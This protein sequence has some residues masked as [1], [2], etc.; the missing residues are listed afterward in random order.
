MESICDYTQCT[1][2]MACLNI[3]PHKAIHIT[4]DKEGF[5]RPHIEKEKC[6]DCGLCRQK[7]PANTPVSTH[8][9]IKIYS[10]WNKDENTRMQSSSGGA[11][12]ALAIPILKN[13]GVVFGAYLNDKLIVAHTYIEHEQDLHIL[14]GS[15]Y[16]QSDI[17][18]IFRKVKEFLQAGKCVLF[19][20]TPCQI[21]GLKSYLKKGYDN[22]I[23]VD[24][25]CHGV[26]SPT[27]FED[28][29]SWFQKQHNLNDI[30]SIKFRAKKKS[31]IFFNMDIKGYSKSG[32]KLHFTSGYYKDAWIRGF[33][34]DYYLRPS[35]YQCQYTQTNRCSD[36]TI[37]DWWGYRPEKGESKDFESK[38]VS[39]IMCNTS[40][41]NDYFAKYCTQSMILRERTLE[42]ACKTNKS[43]R[44]SF[45]IPEARTQF[46]QDYFELPFEEIV[47][48]YMQPEKT[49]M[50]VWIRT[51]MKPSFARRILCSIFRRIH[52]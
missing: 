46:W 7:C 19:S 22:L 38:G 47:K 20:G 45:K 31:W 30:T 26:P 33:L 43:L 14:Q 25:I 16:V 11:F 21:A 44:E 40:K 27:I 17:N 41:G 36:I 42:E 4:Q 29:K 51:Q 24:L 50:H 39:L 48:K 12:S 18:L 10:G 8:K 52:I 3:C 9:P 2:C 32:K 15:K 23:T 13:S 1:G 37:A 28:W 34:R 35:C 6:V 49:P 5:Y